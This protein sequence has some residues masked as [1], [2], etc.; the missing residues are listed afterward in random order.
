MSYGREFYQMMVRGSEA[1]ARW[2]LE[3]STNILRSKKRMAVLFLLLLPIMLG[4][5]AI[6]AG[7]GTLP[8]MLGGKT[9]VYAFALY[10]P[11][12]LCLD[13]CRASVPVSLPAVSA[14]AAALSSPRH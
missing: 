3:T 4:G 8:D 1:Y 10:Q 13:F 6:A 7:D 14:R 2:D 5:I 9:S 11:Y 12:F